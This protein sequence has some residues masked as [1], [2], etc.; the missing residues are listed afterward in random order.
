MH[1]TLNVGLSTPYTH[2]IPVL[3]LICCGQIPAWLQP[4]VLAKLLTLVLTLVN[5]RASESRPQS[6]YFWGQLS[7]LKSQGIVSGECPRRDND[8]KKVIQDPEVALT[9]A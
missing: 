5:F 7:D 6:L 9:W 3:S 8:L 2:W 1:Q 4:A